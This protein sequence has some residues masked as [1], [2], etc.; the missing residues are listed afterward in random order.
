MQQHIRTS[1]S[2]RI[3]PALINCWINSTNSSADQIN[4]TINCCIFISTKWKGETMV[5][6]CIEATHRHGD[7][8]SKSSAHQYKRT[9][10][11]S[12]QMPHRFIDSSD[13]G[14]RRTII[15]IVVYMYI[16]CVNERPW[17]YDLTSYP[18]QSTTSKSR[19]RARTHANLLSVRSQPKSHRFMYWFSKKIKTNTDRTNIIVVIVVC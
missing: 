4:G 15:T 16:Q 2:S 1:C 7:T 12:S 18:T 13:E 3:N 9:C 14:K 8:A 10:C 5:S 17:S 19:P 11:L 6:H